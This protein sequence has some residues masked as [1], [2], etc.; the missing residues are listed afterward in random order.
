M[1]G[2]KW[3]LCPSFPSPVLPQA[4]LGGWGLELE[5]IRGPVYPA[6]LCRDLC[7][8]QTLPPDTGPLGGIV[9]KHFLFLNHI[10]LEALSAQFGVRCVFQGLVVGASRGS[11]TGS[12]RELW[13]IE[14]RS[15][16]AVVSQFGVSNLQ[17]KPSSSLR[18]SIPTSLNLSSKR[19]SS[20]AFSYFVSCPLSV[21]D[22]S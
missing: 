13:F 21:Q 1:C 20:R 2:T 8:W 16:E 11:W 12:C 14:G 22:Q 7:C 9:R 19:K 18:D 3:L 17:G 5:D 10:S 6:F 15:V 4:A